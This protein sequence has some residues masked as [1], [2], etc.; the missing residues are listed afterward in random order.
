VGILVNFVYPPTNALQGRLRPSRGSLRA[1][2]RI[3]YT[4]HLSR[5]V[6]N[7]TYSA[8]IG[9]DPLG[10]QGAADAAIIIFSLTSGLEKARLGKAF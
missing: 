8:P 6:D 10:G 3:S 2:W 1:R 7:Q 5:D 9:D 4:A